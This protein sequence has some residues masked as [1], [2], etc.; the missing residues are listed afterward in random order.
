MRITDDGSFRGVSVSAFH[1]IRGRQHGLTIGIVNIADELHGVQLG[2][3]NIARNK[4]SF[5][6]LPLFNYSR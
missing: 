5:R 2:L 1:D 4:A 6:V 3:I